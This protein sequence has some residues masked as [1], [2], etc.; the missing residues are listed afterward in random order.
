M[1]KKQLIFE[2]R[3]LKADLNVQLRERLRVSL[4]TWPEISAADEMWSRQTSRRNSRNTKKRGGGATAEL[5]DLG[6][7]KHL[8]KMHQ[9][10]LLRDTVEPSIVRGSS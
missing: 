4:D 7:F 10:V 5:G 2:L 8:L 3:L 6:C 1:P 9:E